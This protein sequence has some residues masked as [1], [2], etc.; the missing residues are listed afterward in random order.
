MKLT[1]TEVRNAK[2]R[3]KTYRLFDGEGMYLEV[4]PRGGTY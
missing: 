1:A 4:T 2:P 3:S